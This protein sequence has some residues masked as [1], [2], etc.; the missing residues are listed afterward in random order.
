MTR[1]LEPN[2][3]LIFTTQT[4][5]DIRIVP[6]GDLQIAYESGPQ[7][8]NSESPVTGLDLIERVRNAVALDRI[9]KYTNI[10]IYT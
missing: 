9:R 1:F 4:G 8:Y 3:L 2:C 10:N 5:T 7:R 6:G